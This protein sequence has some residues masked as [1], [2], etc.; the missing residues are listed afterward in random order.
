[1]KN[2]IHYLNRLIKVRGYCDTVEMVLNYKIYF[3]MK[4]V[5]YYLYFVCGVHYRLI[6]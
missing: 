4:C 6:K 3:S 2:D 5:M 1:M